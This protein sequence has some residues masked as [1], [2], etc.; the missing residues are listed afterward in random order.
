MGSQ[1]KNVPNDAFTAMRPY[2]VKNTIRCAFRFAFY[3]PHTR[4]L[5]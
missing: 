4:D 5:Q 3:L 2:F 1:R